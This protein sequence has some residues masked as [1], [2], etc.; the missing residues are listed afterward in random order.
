MTDTYRHKGLRARLVEA[1]K[2]KGI[3]DERV[4]KAIAEVP[5]H[6][7]MES[8]LETKAYEDIALPISAGQ[9]ISQPFTVATQTSLLK[10]AHGDKVLEVG[11]GSGYQ[12]CILLAMG[13]KVYTTERQIEL[14]RKA[15]ELL[16]S[17]G[18]HP[19]FFFS[20]GSLGLP[21]YGPF[22]KIIV[23]AG[24]LETPNELMSQ[25][26]IGG[27]MVIPVGGKIQSMLLYTRLTETS[28]SKTDHGSFSFVPLLKGLV[29]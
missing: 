23:T 3:T 4:L 6:L 10:I 27:M 16:P 29:K 11:T 28:F 12:A 17:L 9:T 26:K 2:T 20:D 25:L 8:F 15:K 13:A 18:Y 1:L 24:A 14:Y 22:D 21:T 7:F 19:N 5:R